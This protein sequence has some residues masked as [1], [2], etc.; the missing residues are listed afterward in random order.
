M[1]LCTMTAPQAHLAWDLLE[2]PK[3]LMEKAKPSMC[4]TFTTLAK[5]ELLFC[6]LHETKE[7]K[8]R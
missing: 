1:V 5:Q 4:Q 8:H 2:H 3:A 7:S 6:Q